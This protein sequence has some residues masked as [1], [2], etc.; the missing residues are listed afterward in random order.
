MR[1][2]D[3]KGKVF[4]KVN[5]IDFLVILFLIGLVPVFYFGDKV[6][7]RKEVVK[8]FKKVPVQI[9]CAS[10]MPEL[11]DVFREGDVIEDS[12]GN[13]MGFLKKIISN[14]VSEIFTIN[15]F[16]VRNDE[17]F[18]VPNPSGKDVVCLVEL[19]CTEDKGSLYFNRYPVKVGCNIILGT[20]NYNIQGVIINVDRGNLVT[21]KVE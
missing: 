18:L 9:K 13:A 10:I 14:K 15:Q 7:S 4:G 5:L 2:I 12:D 19:I 8:D 6:L 21:N 1:F 3:E 16:N 11:A 17:Y 20:D